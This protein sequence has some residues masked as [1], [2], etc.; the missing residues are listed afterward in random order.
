MNR[1]TTDWYKY[2]T[3][4]KGPFAHLVTQLFMPSLTQCNEKKCSLD[5]FKANM[6]REV[7]INKMTSKPDGGLWTSTARMRRHPLR[8]KE[9]MYSSDWTEWVRREMPDWFNPQGILIEPVSDNVF[10]IETDDDTEEL[11]EMF[12]KEKED[13]RMSMW[14]SGPQ[15]DW[16]RA[17]SDEGYDGIHWGF[18]NGDPSDAYIGHEQAW[19]VESTCWRSDAVQ[20]GMIKPLSVVTIQSQNW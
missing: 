12:P 15:I 9:H 11:A 14:S 19:D 7:G 6:P 10:H 3:E 17:L 1:I 2:I 16:K 18:P 5:H 20:K 13:S 8:M 4:G